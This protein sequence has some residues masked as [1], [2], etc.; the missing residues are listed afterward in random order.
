MAVLI[1]YEVG[2]VLIMLVSV[3]SLLVMVLA[4]TWPNGST[5]VDVVHIQC[6]NC[7]HEWD[8]E[9]ECSQPGRTTIVLEKIQN[10]M[11]FK[12]TQGFLRRFTND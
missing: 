7:Q 5:E 4:A 6:C 10:T 9:I 3:G 2:I 8:Q 1:S 12:K 11:L